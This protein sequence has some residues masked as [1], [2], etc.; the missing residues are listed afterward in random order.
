VLRGYDQTNNLILEDSKERVYS[1]DKGVAI[2]KL[3]LYLIR[4][5]NV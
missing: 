1:L 5:D 2:F 4:G 3:G